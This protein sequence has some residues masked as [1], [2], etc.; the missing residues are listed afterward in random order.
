MSSSLLAPGS[1][2]GVLVA[3]SLCEVRKAVRIPAFIIPVIVFPAMFYVMFA[4][5]MGG[6]VPGAGLTMPAY[7]LASYGTFGVVGA[8]LFGMGV[9]VA[10]ERGQGWLLLK[11][12][13]PMPPLAYFGGK[14]VMS[15]AIGLVIAVLLA[16]LGTTLG[17]VRLPATAWALL[18]FVLTF[19]GIP[20]CA[21][22]CA[23]GYVSG[24]NSAPP[25]ANLIYLPMSLASGLWIP[26]EV[27]PDFVRAIAPFMPP[28]H[29]ARLALAT[30]GV[31]TPVVRH[32]AA[33]GAFTALFLALAI[34]AYRRDDGRTW[35]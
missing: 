33:L 12:A 1:F 6:V 16:L 14:V 28:Y 13:T 21:L 10:A 18:L 29:L 4:L 31:D 8:A 32:V 15:M 35:G 19:G 11:R 27:M 25:L 22:G 2:G 3:E 9:G 17:G 7:L 23:L 30:I 5:L 24:P 34:L 20:F 26:I